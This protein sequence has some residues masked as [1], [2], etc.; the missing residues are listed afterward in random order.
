MRRAPT[1]GGV[2]LLAATAALAHDLFIKLDRYFL[3]PGAS[4][5]VPVLNGTFLVSE[6]SLEGDRIAD[7]SL[8]SPAGRERL[9]MSA[10][11]ARGDTSWV[12]LSVGEAGTYVVGLS[13]RPRELELTGEEFNAYLEEDGIANILA[14]RRQKN[15]MTKGARERYSKHVKAVFQAGERRSTGFATALG[16]PAEIV[17]LD[18]PYDLKAG[19]TLRL[20]CLVD[21]KPVAGLTVIS[22]G[23]G[24]GGVAISPRSA[25]TGPDG[26]TAVTLDRAGRWYVKFVHMVPV[27][28]QGLD[29]ESKWATL[30]FGLR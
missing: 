6:N 23:D 18:N 15:E 27:T 21:G 20:R 30:T 19:G 13:V 4:L 12:S 5:S 25:T 8:V 16:Y 3:E 10:W 1:I 14:L 11:S 2:L 9:P 29:Y 26:T 17:P 28:E 22:G 24:P 7:L